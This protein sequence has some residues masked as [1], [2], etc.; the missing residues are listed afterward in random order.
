LVFKIPLI[1][2]HA[3]QK[4]T[5]DII[6]NE[7]FDIYRSVLVI[8][9]PTL[10]MRL[11]TYILFQTQVAMSL[12]ILFNVPNNIGYFWLIWPIVNYSS[13]SFIT[14]AIGNVSNVS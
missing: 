10:K 14:S 4:G 1:T 13:K 3:R 12:C 5:V 11:Y 9:I 7:L 6:P 2:I 8:T